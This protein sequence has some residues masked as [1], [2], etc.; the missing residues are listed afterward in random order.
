MRELETKRE[1][2]YKKYRTE[3]DTDHE[4]YEIDIRAGT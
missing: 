3:N 1:K 2:V 4:Q